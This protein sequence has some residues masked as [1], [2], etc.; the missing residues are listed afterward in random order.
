MDVQSQADEGMAKVAEL[1][2]EIKFGMLTTQCPDG[3]LHS[4]PM[5]TLQMDEDGCLWFFTS[6]QSTKIE[7]IDDQCQ[8]NLAYARI[9]K[10]D[11]LSV[12]GTAELVRDR[13]K[14][15]ALWTPWLKPWFQD[16]LDDPDLIL[17]KVRVDEAD[18]WDAPGS[19][20]KR[21]YGLAKGAMTGDTDALGE[22]GHVR[23]PSMPH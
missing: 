21:L 12:T 16:G 14:M 5:S 7:D 4:R 8:V 3:R 19:S 23:N 15:G 1:V 18:Y 11:Y 10:Q 20:A 13:K 2:K 9:D 22:H 6:Q 17:L